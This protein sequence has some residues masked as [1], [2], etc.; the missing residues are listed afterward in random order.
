M[1]PSLFPSAAVLT[2]LYLRSPSVLFLVL[3]I[4]VSR[5]LFVLLFAF[6]R[7]AY[8]VGLGWILI[9]QSKSRWIVNEVLKRGWLDAN[10][11]PKVAA[12]CKRELE[13]KI[14][15]GTY[16]FEETPKEFTIWLLFR[17]VCR[18]LVQTPAG[19]H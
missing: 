7:L 4:K 1:R 2:P 9:R 3:P 15:R 19:F 16:T 14:G 10:K 6:F 5:I 18:P 13:G 11:R 12:W 17:Q 8:N